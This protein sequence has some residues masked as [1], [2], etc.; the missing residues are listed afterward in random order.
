MKRKTSILLWLSIVFVPV[1]GFS[2]TS[3]MFNNQIIIK[4]KADGEA[5]SGKV[6][7]QRVVNNLETIGGEQ[8]TYKRRLGDSSMVMQLPDG[9]TDEQVQDTL[10]AL[11]LDPA[12]DFVHVDKRMYPA[13]VP[14]DPRY[15]EQWYLHEPFGI[16]LPSAWDIS[17]GSSG[18]VIAVLDTGVLPHRDLSSGRILTLQGVDLISDTY[19]ANDGDGRDSDPTDPGDKVDPN[20]PDFLALTPEQKNS[21]AGCLNNSNNSQSS[22]HGLSVIGVMAATADNTSDIA[23]IDFA[24]RILP[25]RVLGRCGGSVSDIVD[26]MRWAVGLSV[27]GVPDNPNPAKVINLSLSGDG[28]CS[29]GEQAAIDDVRLAGAIVITAAGNEAEEIT[30]NQSEGIPG[31]SPA[32]CEGVIV[33]GAT[34]RSGDQTSYVNFGTAVDVSAPGGDSSDG[35]L[36]LSN[37]GTDG[38]V[39]DTLA[40]IQGTSFT[41]AQVS[42]V[43]SLMYSVNNSLSPQ[44]VEAILSNTTQAFPAGST[45]TTSTCGTGIVNASAA[46]SAA[47]SSSDGGGGCSLNTTQRFD[48]LWLFFMMLASFQL[49]RNYYASRRKNQ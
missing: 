8:L 44:S 32:N 43:A 25:I 12:V 47:Q 14:N 1:A 20:D 5:N 21:L 45:C 46:L 22:W 30:S 28:E 4:Y 2:A 33:V 29:A 42:A 3:E 40:L 37:T 31:K 34:T 13:F 18:V 23:G 36:T 48:P 49:A 15:D 16:N 39:L 24:A 6:R 17:T 7:P 35:V 41:T 11:M 19:T 27:T 10:N 26:A 38:P 9:L